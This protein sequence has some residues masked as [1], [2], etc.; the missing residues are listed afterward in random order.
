MGFESYFKKYK[1][2][3]YIQSVYTRLQEKG[4]EFFKEYRYELSD[5]L[6][7]ANKHS[8][9]R[10]ITDFIYGRL[11]LYKHFKKSVFDPLEK[12]GKIDRL[13]RVYFSLEYDIRSFFKEFE[14]ASRKFLAHMHKLESL[15]INPGIKRK[16]IRL[17]FE[18]FEN[19]P[20]HIVLVDKV[21]NVL[22]EGYKRSG[23][24]DFEKDIPDLVDLYLFDRR[25]D[26]KTRSNILADIGKIIEED[27]LPGYTSKLTSANELSSLIRMFPHL[28]MGEDEYLKVDNQ[29]YTVK[30]FPAL[31]PW[32]HSTRRRVS[33]RHREGDIVRTSEFNQIIGINKLTHGNVPRVLVKLNPDED[34]FMTGYNHPM[35]FDTKRNRYISCSMPCTKQDRRTK[36]LVKAICEHERMRRSSQKGQEKTIRFIDKNI[37]SCNS[38]RPTPFRKRSRTSPSPYTKRSKK[39]RSRSP[40]RHIPSNPFRKREKRYRRFSKRKKKNED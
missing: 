5:L 1:S 34:P 33:I 26:S 9:P 25:L 13:V 6:R 14:N 21:M 7:V 39:K 19:K 16:L 37:K 29:L 27:S 12:Y 20:M 10:K 18:Y 30:T 35:L 28:R 40:S 3:P 22:V 17:L 15:D 38:W 36:K 8:N 32:P 11:R 31:K 2:N 4:T 23:E 24:G